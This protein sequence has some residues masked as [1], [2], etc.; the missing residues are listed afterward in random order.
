[1]PEDFLGLFDSETDVVALQPGELLF[2]EGDAAV[3]VYV[4]KSGELQIINGNHV[5]ETVRAGGMVGEMALIS[6]DVRSATVRATSESVVIPIDRKRFLFLV[7]QTPFF[8]LKVMRV[9][10]ARLKLMNDSLTSLSK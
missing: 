10:C 1:L 3:Y 9:M 4:V 8:A 7:Q 2:R 5:Y 6:D